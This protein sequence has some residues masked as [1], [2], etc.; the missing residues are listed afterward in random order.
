[1]LEEFE[2]CEAEEVPDAEVE[3]EVEVPVDVET[4]L[5]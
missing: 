3:V 4:A 2:V 1:V 5:M